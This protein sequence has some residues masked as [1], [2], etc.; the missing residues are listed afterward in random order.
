M[1]METLPI[2][3]VIMP[4]YNKRHYVKRA[5][6]SIQKQ[7]LTDWELIIVDDGSTDGST[8]EVPQNDSRIQMIHQENKGPGAA[9]NRGIRMASGKFITFIDADN[10]YYPQKLQV[11]MEQLWQKKNANWMISAFEYEKDDKIELRYIHDINNN[12]IKAQPLVFDNAINELQLSGMPSEGMCIKRDLLG[13]LSGFNE[14]MR[15]F[16]N[17]EFIIRYAL[18]QPRVVICPRPLYRVIDIPASAFKISSHRIEGERQMGESLYKL[19]ENYSEYSNFLTSKSKRILINY[20]IALILINQK[21][22]ARRYLT[23]KFPF[24]RNIRW[25]KVWLGSWMP[26]WL[27]HGLFKHKKT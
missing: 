17:T 11:E 16:E 1:I 25:W 3:S 10:Y 4:L 15:C 13:P 12:E 6:E 14:D 26:I 24:S 5:I 22:E 23:N 8:D 9:R 18:M 20:A 7:T 27:L 21:K 2:I 19:S